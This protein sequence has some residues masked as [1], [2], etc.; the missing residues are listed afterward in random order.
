MKSYPKLPLLSMSEMVTGREIIMPF[1]NTYSSVVGDG[2]TKVS[3][4]DV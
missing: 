2:L 4:W 1:D 3:S